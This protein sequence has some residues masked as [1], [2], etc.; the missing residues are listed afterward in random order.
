[1][2]YCFGLF[3]FLASSVQPGG[4]RQTVVSKK[5]A[6]PSSYNWAKPFLLLNVFRSDHRYN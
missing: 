4:S 1:M 3:T 5:T 2:A 6:L